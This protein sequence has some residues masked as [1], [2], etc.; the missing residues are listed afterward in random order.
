MVCGVWCVG[1]LGR[2]GEAVVEVL[3]HLHA[4]SLLHITITE[5]KNRQVL[6]VRE[7]HMCGCGCGCGVG[8]SQIVRISLCPTLVVAPHHTLSYLGGCSQSST[9]RHLEFSLCVCGCVC[10]GVCVCVS[11]RADSED[12]GSSWIAG[13]A[14]GAGGGGRHRDGRTVSARGMAHAHQ[15]SSEARSGL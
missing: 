8:A 1:G 14:A 11:A 3:E 9:R 2:S 10:V 4:S 5:G 7:H 15:R 13:D 6:P 12:V